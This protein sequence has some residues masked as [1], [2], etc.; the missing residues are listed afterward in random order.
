MSEKVKLTKEQAETLDALKSEHAREGI[1][2][3]FYH[4]N[5]WSKMYPCLLD[6]DLDTVIRALYRP[7]DI[8]IEKTVEEQLLYRYAETSSFNEDFREGYRSG[9]VGTL[10]IIGMKV[11]GIN[12]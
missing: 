8:T 2:T 6:L 9:I 10:N 1:V 5:N 11:K 7:E 12:D 4:K 3:A